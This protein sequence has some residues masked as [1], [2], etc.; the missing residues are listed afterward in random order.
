MSN[1]Y[2][3]LVEVLPGESF[4][5]ARALITETVG[6]YW[7]TEEYNFKNK[8]YVFACFSLTPPYTVYNW[9]ND[10]KLAEFL[11]MG[12]VVMYAKTN[13]DGKEGH[14]QNVYVKV[15]PA[16]YISLVTGEEIV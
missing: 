1:E 2:G 11:K 8:T 9:K 5:K 16:R 4:K 3:Y 15:S 7:R 10:E 13:R 6:Y 12:R 14:V